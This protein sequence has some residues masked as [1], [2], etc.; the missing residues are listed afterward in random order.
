MKTTLFFFLF[1][2]VV[3][4]ISGQ[5]GKM[6]NDEMHAISLEGNLIGD[7]PKRNILVYLP[8]NYDKQPEVRYP[9]VYLLHGFSGPGNQTWMIE[10]QGL[11]MN[12]RIIMDKLIAEQKV[13]PMVIVMPDGR[14]KFG[15]S[16]YT[17]SI[18]TGNWEDFATRDLVS[19]IDEKY[20][21]IS[22]AA[23]RGIAGHSMS[24]YS[25]VKLAMKNP[26]IYGSIYATSPC[27]LDA[28][29]NVNTPSRFMIEA[30]AVKSWEEI[31]RATFLSRTFIA[32]A[33]AFSPNPA[34]PPF[35]AD[36]PVKVR[37]EP[38]AV[39]EQ[40]L[41]RWLA[42]TPMWMIDQYRANLKRLRGIAFDVG[43]SEDLLNSIRQFSGALKRNKIEHLF[44][45]FD[46]DH[47]DKTAVRIETR[48][49]PFFS[50]TLAFEQRSI[51]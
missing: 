36:F 10:N 19:F 26:D 9:V 40:A 44:E 17:N 39:A 7:S 32:S 45:E 20:R 41:A 21:T 6:I 46:G 30:S 18:T 14:N 8:P 25:A 28:Y 43:T 29:P 27:C 15:G 13:R 23:S 31:E 47:I 3:V 4:S 5:S 16:F 35:F 22:K 38:D 33:A 24:G 2:A 42:N 37:G 12:M 34:K 51:K 50:R 49:M 48:I 1:V 11:R